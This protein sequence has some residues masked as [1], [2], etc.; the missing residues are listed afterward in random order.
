M[1]LP[2][3]VSLVAL[4][5]LSLAG[6]ADAQSTANQVLPGTLSQSGCPSGQAPC[7][8]PISS[9]NPLSV[10]DSAVLAAITASA[11]TPPLSVKGVAGTDGSTTV[12]A[13]GTAQNLFSGATPANGF[14][15]CNPDASEVLW[16]SD[17]TTAAA[18]ATGSVM[19]PAGGSACYSVGVGPG[20]RPI[21]AVS[22]YGATTGHKITASSW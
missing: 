12:T 11:I 15:V 19:V 10:L 3:I 17:T 4:A 1:T 5:V 7:F 8:S 21:Q 2:K 6:R 13:G 16:V 22:V 20:R 9:A 14:A 18:N